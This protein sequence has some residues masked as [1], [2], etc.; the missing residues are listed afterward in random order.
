MKAVK[1]LALSA[2]AMIVMGLAEATALARDIREPYVDGK[3]YPKDSVELVRMLDDFLSRVPERR[4]PAGD[5]VALVVPHAGYPYSGQVAAH[6]YRQIEGLSFDTVILIGPYHRAFFEGASVWKSG[7]WRTPLGDLEVDEDLAQAI[8]EYHERFQFI[9]EAHGTEHSLEVQL[10]FLQRVLKNFKIVPIAISD[11][12]L[13]NCHLLAEAILKA[14]SDAQKRVLILASTDLSHYHADPVARQK[15][16]LTLDLLEKKD[17][18]ALSKELHLETSELCGSAATLTVLEIAHLMGDTDLQV[19]KYANSGD[20]T[21]EKDRVVGYAAAVLYK[22]S[23][24]SETSNVMLNREQQKE[25]LRIAR[26][27]IETYVREGKLIELLVDDLGLDE[28]GAVFVTIRKQGELRGCIGNTAATEPLYLAVRNMAIQ[29]ASNDFRFRP[30]ER[31]ELKNIR[32]EISVLSPAW[33]VKNA[34]GIVLGK[35]GVIVVSGEKSGIFLPKV[36]TETG[37]SKEKFLSEL[38]SQKAGLLPNAWRDGT[39][40][41]YVFTTQD[42]GELEDARWIASRKH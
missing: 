7:S 30:V 5:L 14:M 28:P 10:P 8:L 17:A 3:F 34:D 33:Q 42:F 21:G 22:N 29:A 37:W 11:P 36:A 32:I 31:G 27:A 18:A 25:L 23:K 26:H 24:E 20:V 39:A 19:L 1:I 38:C 12:T 4:K 9:P 2:G 40:E 13:E 35:H 15:D 16:R 6:A 41:L